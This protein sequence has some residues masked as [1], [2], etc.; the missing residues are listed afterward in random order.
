MSAELRE[1]G[2]ITLLDYKRRATH[3]LLKN[4]LKLVLQ[5]SRVL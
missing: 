4:R 2:V 1:T 5:L 3:A